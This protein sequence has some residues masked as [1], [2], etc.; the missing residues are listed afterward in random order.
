MSIDRLVPVLV[1][2]CTRLTKIA[3]ARRIVF[4]SG[5]D[6]SFSQLCTL[7]ILDTSDHEPSLH[8]LADQ[9]GLSVAAAG[10]AVDAMVREGLLARREDE[11]DRRVKRISLAGPGEQLL[12]RLTEAH[13][14]GLRAFAERLTER[15]RQSL[16]DAL[17]PILAQPELQHPNTAKESR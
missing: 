10:R 4:A 5:L 17:A 1:G 12:L 11:H 14:E 2:F 7:F 6:L 9:L 3:E 8:E 13:T 15:E 16:H